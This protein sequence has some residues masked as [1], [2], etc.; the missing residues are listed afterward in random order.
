[1][2]LFTRLW[3]CFIVLL[4]PAQLVAQTNDEVI[5]K[6]NAALGLMSFTMVPD[7]TTSNLSIGKGDGESSDLLLS[8][9]GGGAT[10][11]KEVPVYLE[12]NLSFSRYDPTFVISKG[13][14]TSVIPLKWNSVSVSGGVGWDFPI[15]ENWVLRPIANIALGTVMSDITVAGWVIEEELGID[16]DFLDGGRLDAFGYGGSLM[17]DY[18]LFSKAQD[19]DAELRYSYIRLE[20]FGSTPDGIKGQANAENL[21]LYLR[22]R[23]PTGVEWLQRPLRYVMEGAHTQ[24]FGEQRGA[25]GFKY[26]SSVGLGLELD[27]SAYTKIIS[28]TRL[29]ARYM[30]SSNTEG[31]SVGLAMSF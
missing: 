3:V 5:K 4:S 10:M 8:Q 17:L 16:L 27:S 29:V 25:L 13:D 21:S 28:R 24:F 7:V 12:G 2:A 11:S 19:I 15:A 18:E 14:K 31:Y 1:M 23:A 6:A 22:R 30:F 26:L 20:S 9:V